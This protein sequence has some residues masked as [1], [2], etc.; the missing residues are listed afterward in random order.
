[1][2]MRVKQ[3]AKSVVLRT[4]GPEL[5]HSIRRAYVLFQIRRNRHYHE[6]EMAL[7]RSLVRGGDCAFDVG[8]NVGV[9][10]NELSL[11]VGS[12]GKV[13]SFE[14]VAENYDILTALVGKASLANVFPHRLAVGAKAAECKI[15]IPEMDGFLGYYWAH[16]A[17]ESEDG[18]AETVKMI[19]IDELC[20]TE[21]V[22]PPDFIKCDVEGGEFGVISGGQEMLRRH[23][24]GWLIEVSR[25]TSAQVFSALQDFGYRAFVLEG[26]LRETETYLDTKFSNY[27]FLHPQSPCWER[28]QTS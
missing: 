23:R 17:D 13:H 25:D 6:P 18:R 10:T 22:D 28:V 12:T 15:L 26:K 4:C 19:S 14:P 7:I 5:R 20:R 21:P 8:A 9:Y 24:P 11:A 1:M 2:G 3:F 16:I 27:F